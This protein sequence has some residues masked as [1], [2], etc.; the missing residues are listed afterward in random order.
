MITY[1]TI[2]FCLA[3]L[4][5]VVSVGIVVY[6]VYRFQR[7]PDVLKNIESAC[8][9]SPLN[10]TNL[11]IKNPDGL[12]IITADIRNDV[13]WI[14]YRMDCNDYSKPNSI[15]TLVIVNAKTDKFCK[16]VFED[17][18]L[19][20]VQLSKFGRKRGPRCITVAERTFCHEIHSL[21][22]QSIT[23]AKEVA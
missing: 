8:R 19:D 13:I 21:V 10:T 4:A 23:A 14:E 3:I 16:I 5:T 1:E 6:I 7:R 15:T 9:S 11:R 22:C 18:Y 12:E 20:S 2:V 17:G